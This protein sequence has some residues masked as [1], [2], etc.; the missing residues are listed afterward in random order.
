MLDTIH[1]GR[2]RAEVRACHPAGLAMRLGSFA[3]E[4]HSG[5]QNEIPGHLL[6]RE[7]KFI[8]PKPHVR[9]RTR[10]GV[11]LFRGI[12]GSCAWEAGRAYVRL[13]LKFSQARFRAKRR[14]AREENRQ[15]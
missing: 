2:I 6:P 8:P 9:A 3:D 13:C 14:N 15:Q 5:S 7:M 11:N 12:I 4:F 10:N 1:V